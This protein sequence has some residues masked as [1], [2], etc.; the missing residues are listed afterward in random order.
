MVIDT[1]GKVT[2]R[3]LLLGKKESNVYLLKAEDE[4]A[5]I[6][7]G[8]IHIAPHVIEQLIRFR[9][10]E[11]LIKRIII[12]HA[13][14]DHCGLVPFLKR[15]WP[16]AR[17]T[18]SSRANDLLSTPAV[19]NTIKSMN[20]GI[21]AMFGDEKKSK[22][23]DFEFT[24]INVEDIVKEGDILPCGNLSIEILEVPGHSSCSIAAYVPEDKAMF[25]SDAGGIPLG[26]Q[27]FA[28]GNSNFDK[29]QSNLER[30]AEFDI[31]I[32]LAEH[33]GAFTGEDGREFLNRS[34]ESAQMT[35]E[36]IVNSFKRTM[37]EQ[38]TVDEITDFFTK[39]TSDYFLSKDVISL[40]VG[41]MVRFFSKKL[42]GEKA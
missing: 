7:G 37:D 22:E 14:F 32:H 25:A 35:R 5:L 36:L 15:R 28:A 39:G 23:M 42:S 30:M 17:V 40:V 26:D 1:P 33:G 4:Y 41:Q 8:M 38:K 31:E 27:I 3:I 9:I 13:H 12:L 6:G 11:T 20:Q 16:W 24:E 10:D 18:A 29:F 19:I 21:F 34:I 2:D